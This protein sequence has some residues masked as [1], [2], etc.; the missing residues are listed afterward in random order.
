MRLRRT[1]TKAG[2]ITAA[3]YA[4][5]GQVAVCII[6]LPPPVFSLIAFILV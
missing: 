2:S 1:V 3:I 4:R 6:L 5:Q